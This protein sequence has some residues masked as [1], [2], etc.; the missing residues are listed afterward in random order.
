M[1][2]IVPTLALYLV[3]MSYWLGC[4]LYGARSTF[5]PLGML[6]FFTYGC[7]GAVLLS[8]YLEAIP[9]PFHM[10]TGTNYADVS[11]STWLTGPA[12]EEF[13]KALPVFLLAAFASTAR[14]MGI[15]DFALAAFTTGLGFGFVETNFYTVT[16]QDGLGAMFGADVHAVANFWNFGFEKGQRGVYAIYEAGHWVHAGLVGLALGVGVRLWPNDGRKWLPAVAMLAL[17]S[18][19]HSLWNF[20][21]QHQYPNSFDLASRPVE[22]LYGLT[23]HGLLE[24]F[25]LPLLLIAAT[26][27]EARLTDP[28]VPAPED[29]RLPG[30]TGG[31]RGELR[32][33]WSR[34]GLG[35][36]PVLKTLGYFRRRRAYALAASDAA[37]TPGRAAAD[38]YALAARQRL[39]AERAQVA[40]PAAARALPTQ[41]QLMAGGLTL[42]KA[43]RSTVAISLFTLLVFGV[44]PHYLPWLHHGAVVWMAALLAAGFVGW[45]VFVFLRLPVPTP[46]TAGGEL[47]V[48][49]H[50]R[51]V[52]L[53]ASAVSAGLPLLALAL[54]KATLLP[55]NHL[56]HGLTALS[57]WA[58]GGG[59]TSTLFSAAG[60]LAAA[61]AVPDNVSEPQGLE[62][63]RPAGVDGAGPGLEAAAMPD[64]SSA[65]DLPAQST[66]AVLADVRSLGDDVSGGADGPGIFEPPN[67]PGT[68][69][70]LDAVGADLTD[71]LDEGAPASPD[72]PPDVEID[73][74]SDDGEGLVLHAPVRT[75]G[76]TAPPP[77]A[78]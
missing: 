3:M 26:W 21:Q 30:E 14:R 64:I 19:D 5:S 75:A 39:E 6:S 22:L 77:E 16:A 23:L 2:P 55:A 53:T 1:P 27:W 41:A 59:S 52:L 8:L 24:V 43:Y 61:A 7:V 45:R 33:L 4:R 32:L 10:E 31:L 51:L 73:N 38:G 15:A 54:H 66:D 78:P 47:L 44:A 74:G 56:A 62:E 72:A 71:L 40:Q 36:G 60:A 57:A 20:K 28:A 29:L 13:A 63:S 69:D 65:A 17:V 58:A 12:I 46:A 25:A 37:R 42:A 76:S 70:A 48:Q 67:G 34:R 35:A 11:P 49:R 50:M 18:F 9:L 68:L